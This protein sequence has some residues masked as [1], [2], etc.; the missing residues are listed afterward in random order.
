MKLTPQ[1]LQRLVKEELEVILTD[2]EAVELFGEQIR[3]RVVEK[4]G[5]GEGTPAD[6]EWS[7]K[8]EYV[9][10][11]EAQL[12]L[13]GFE[14]LP[15]CVPA[16]GVDDLSSQL[17][18]MVVDSQLAPEDLNGLM[19]LIYDKVAEDLEGI[20]VEDEEDSDEYRRTTMGFMEALK[21]ETI[22]K[23]IDEQQCTAGQCVVPAG[24]EPAEGEEQ[25]Y[26]ARLIDALVGTGS[27]PEEAIEMAGWNKDW[28]EYS[29]WLPAAKPDTSKGT[30][31]DYL[32]EQEELNRWSAIA[33][34]PPRLA[35]EIA[36]VPFE[37]QQ[38][39]D[40]MPDNA[41]VSHLRGATGPFEPSSIS[42]LARWIPAEIER[43]RQA[44][45]ARAPLKGFL[46]SDIDDSEEEELEEKKQPSE[47]SA[48]KAHKALAKTAKK[49][50]P[51]DKKRQDQYIYGGKRK[52]GWKPKSEKKQ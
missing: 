44:K 48:K 4:L 22:K 18:K 46:R 15:T 25:R 50:F 32:K 42:P 20:G 35:E 12:E 45:S 13:P 5:F 52:M 49:K 31:P 38:V 17:A 9:V 37:V 10:E 16:D 8:K 11:E 3:K 28:G 33:G 26:S 21:R 19:E 7:K 6:D 29:K 43:R 1:T 39:L 14:A 40:D 51:K 23:M 47:K 36:P 30:L 27:K 34:L 24:P 2:D 41:L